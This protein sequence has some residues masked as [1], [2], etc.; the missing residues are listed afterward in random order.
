MVNKLV[1]GDYVATGAGIARAQ[2]AEAAFCNAL[3]RL[4]CRRGSFPFLPKLGS[5][6]WRLGLER[7]AN[8]AVLARQYCAE[9]LSG[10]GV[11]A[12]SVEVSERGG[13]IVVEM[14]LTQGEYTVSVEVNV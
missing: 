13:A 14:E 7:P 10:S 8:R 2:G 5:R 3:F 12:A 11:I 9:A 1:N 4:Q 6:L